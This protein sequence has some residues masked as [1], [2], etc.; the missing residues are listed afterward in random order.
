M[1]VIADRLS[2]MDD[3]YFPRAFLEG[4][5]NSDHRKA[6]LLDLL[7]R[8]APLFLGTSFILN[9]NLILMRTLDLTCFV[10]S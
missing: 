9:F 10:D 3:L 4:A 2:A 6:A 7:I 5:H 8:D 1:E